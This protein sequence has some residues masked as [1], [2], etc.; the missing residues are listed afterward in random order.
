MLWVNVRENEEH[1]ELQ[2]EEEDG[3][4]E[5]EDNDDGPSKPTV[6]YYARPYH[7]FFRK[8]ISLTSTQTVLCQKD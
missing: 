7:F 5:N 3:E 1:E 4:E 2:K 8:V 6:S